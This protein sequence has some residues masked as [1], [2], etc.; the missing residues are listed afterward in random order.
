M[1]STYL[2]LSGTLG[3][4]GIKRA[5]NFQQNTFLGLHYLNVSKHNYSSTT[6]AV[7]SRTDPLMIVCNEFKEIR[8]EGSRKRQK[9]QHFHRGPVEED[10]AALALGVDAKRLP[11]AAFAAISWQN[12]HEKAS[13]PFEFGAASLP[14]NGPSPRRSRSATGSHRA[15][16]VASASTNG[17]KA[18]QRSWGQEDPFDEVLVELAQY[19]AEQ[20]KTVQPKLFSMRRFTEEGRVKRDMQRA[21]EKE[22]GD[23]G[24]VVRRSANFGAMTPREEDVTDVARY[25]DIRSMYLTQ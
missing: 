23:F 12:W 5:S 14:T 22:L 1:S 2:P 16:S 11:H 25:W 4:L 19:L 20:R 13:T 15:V 7:R 9:L 24:E 6:A 21:L 18:S 17:S 8:E 3:Y 10:G